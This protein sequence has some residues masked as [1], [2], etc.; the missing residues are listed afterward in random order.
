MVPLRP[1]TVKVLVP[2]ASTVPAAAGGVPCPN[3]PPPKPPKPMDT[4]VAVTTPEVVVPSTLTISPLVTLVK[5]GEVTL[6][7]L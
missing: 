3:M 4:L 1:L 7:S 2:T 6:P 5:L